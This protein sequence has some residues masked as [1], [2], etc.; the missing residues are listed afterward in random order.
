[1]KKTITY[2]GQPATVACDENC[3]KAWGINTR[4]RN[5]LSDNEDDWEW[6]T[7]Q[8]LGDAPIDPGTQEG[9]HSKSINKKDIPNKW[10]VN[11]CE[12]CVMSAYG[13]PNQQ[14]ELLDFSKRI[15]NIKS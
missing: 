7:D 8:E 14:L 5:Q 4:P 10:C 15:K 12:R 11:Q 2:C 9:F 1:M 3:N 6:L 13:K